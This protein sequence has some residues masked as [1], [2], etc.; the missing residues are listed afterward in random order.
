MR[1]ALVFPT[2]QR[3]IIRKAQSQLGLLGRPLNKGEKAISR[4]FAI[5]KRVARLYTGWLRY[6]SYIVIGLKSGIPAIQAYFF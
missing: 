5:V 1:F 2:K 3:L 4:P 6:R